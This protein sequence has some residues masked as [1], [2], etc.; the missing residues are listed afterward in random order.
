M[1][2]IFILFEVDRNELNIKDYTRKHGLNWISVVE[3]DGMKKL[4]LVLYSTRPSA[5]L[6]SGLIAVGGF[7]SV[8]E[9]VEVAYIFMSIFSCSSF[10]FLVND[11]FDR[12]KDL[13]NNKKRP[14]ATGQVSVNLAVI[15]AAI[16]WLFFL[17]ISIKLGINTT[18]VC[19][20][21]TLLILAYSWINSKY[22]LLANMIVSI[23][24]SLYFLYGAILSPLEINTYL[25]MGFIFFVILGREILLDWLDVAGDRAVGKS[26]IPILFSPRI[27][28]LFVAGSFLMASLFIALI[29]PFAAT[30]SLILLSLALMVMWVPFILILSNPSRK[31]ILFNI[32]SSHLI[33]LFIFLE[34]IL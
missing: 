12:K 34:L 28:T 13:L 21:S 15:V 22:G 5:G 25:Y 19:L 7:G 32:R 11:L 18:T 24:V 26:S 6:G 29:F 2:E 3:E 23:T 17:L 8:T 30:T 16:F 1:I 4:G 14:I 20:V 31:N 33:L 9:S 27:T 10:C